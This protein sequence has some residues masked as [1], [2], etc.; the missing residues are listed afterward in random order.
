MGH[1]GGDTPPEADEE[2]QAEAVDNVAMEV[3]RQC[4]RGTTLEIGGKEDANSIF[5]N[6]SSFVKLS[7][8]NDTVQEVVL[9][10]HGDCHRVYNI[11]RVLADGFDNLEALRVLTICPKFDDDDDDHAGHEEVHSLY[12]KA[13]T[14]ALSR[15]RCHVELR[16]V[17]DWPERFYFNK[18][19]EALKGLS[20]IRTFHSYDDAVDWESA[21]ILMASLASMPSLEN[22]T[23][24][25]FWY[26]R[27]PPAGEFPA[28][29]NLLKSPSLRSIEFSRIQLT[30]GLSRALQ[31]AFEE[32]S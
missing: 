32:G 18:F 11:M 3:I 8:G 7:Q 29:T 25:S 4:L 1:N 15:V 16:L 5:D 20:T 21:D 10:L 28:L 31:A 12:H 24:G 19:T 27:R 14:C 23:L 30:S 9:N 26:E 13:L 17:E 22:V 2:E 6:A